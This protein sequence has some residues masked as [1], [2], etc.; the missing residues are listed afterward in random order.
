MFLW[1]LT[2]TKA[3]KEQSNQVLRFL[4]SIEEKRF[5][6]FSQFK[7][8]VFLPCGFSSLLVSDGQRDAS[9]F[10]VDGWTG[11]NGG[12]AIPIVLSGKTP[13]HAGLSVGFVDTV[14]V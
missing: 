8:L 10:P 1:T 2:L 11:N 12:S 6:F 4:T 3:L 7:R 9:R 13:P 5:I 14:E